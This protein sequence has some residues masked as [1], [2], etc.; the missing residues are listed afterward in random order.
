[1]DGD[2]LPG[3]LS[4][5]ELKQAAEEFLNDA[6]EAHDRLAASQAQPAHA[7]SAAGFPWSNEKELLSSIGGDQPPSEWTDDQWERYRKGL[8]E[9][10]MEERRSKRDARHVRQGVRAAVFKRDGGRCV[11]CGDTESLEFDHIIPHSKGGATSV[12]NLQL[13]CRPCNRTKS[14]KI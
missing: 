2:E 6:T 11:D 3:K 5:E 12:E 4:S 9:L 10:A 13:L 14:N 1:M 7:I 8:G